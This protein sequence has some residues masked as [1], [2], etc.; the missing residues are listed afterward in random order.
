VTKPKSKHK[1]GKSRPTEVETDP[2]VRSSP[3]GSESD[4]E[5]EMEGGYEGARISQWID[6][7][8]D[9]E[10]MEEVEEPV[11]FLVFLTKTSLVLTQRCRKILS[12][13]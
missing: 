10:D 9:E 5:E 12:K 13:V 2:V 6:E 7:G 1:G 4:Q 3:S 8:D 11:S